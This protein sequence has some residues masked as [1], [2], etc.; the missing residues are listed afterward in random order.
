MRGGPPT[1]RL[2]LAGVA[3][4]TAVGTLFAWSL[5]AEDAARD[6]GL[7]Q[8]GAAGV[9]AGAI[10]VFTLVLLGAGRGL[11]RFGPRWRLCVAALA[12]GS[13]LLLA[14]AWQQPLALFVGAAGL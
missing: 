1:S 7:P 14:A 5:V 6:V 8:G 9:F 2:V 12:G 13:G 3:A 10:V 4:N 11:R